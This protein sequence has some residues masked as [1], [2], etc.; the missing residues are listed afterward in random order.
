VSDLNK[1]ISQQ[2]DLTEKW[3]DEDVKRLDIPTIRFSYGFVLSGRI[4]ESRFSRRFAL[5]DT[6]AGEAPEFALSYSDYINDIVDEFR[7]KL[8]DAIDELALGDPWTTKNKQ[9]IDNVIESV[10]MQN[11]S[12]SPPVESGV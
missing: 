12:S 6:K 11:E 9:P 10:E 2:A 8:T 1:T 5:L 7:D 3:L 4:G